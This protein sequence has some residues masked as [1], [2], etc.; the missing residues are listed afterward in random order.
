[1]K[2]NPAPSCKRRCKKQDIVISVKY[3]WKVELIPPGEGWLLIFFASVSLVFFELF[4][5]FFN[6]LFHAGLHGICRRNW[7]RFL[8]SA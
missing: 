2:V 7:H 8:K 3:S 1:M 5:F 4:F 6:L